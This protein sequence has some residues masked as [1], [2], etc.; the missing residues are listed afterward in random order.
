MERREPVAGGSP[1]MKIASA[2]R[3]DGSRV[4][5]LNADSLPRTREC[6][7]ASVGSHVR[8]RQAAVAGPY[9]TSL[10]GREAIL[11]LLCVGQSHRRERGT[12]QPVETGIGSH[13][14]ALAIDQ[15]LPHSVGAEPLLGREDF[16]RSRFQRHG[17]CPSLDMLEP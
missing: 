10:A 1:K 15:Q 3:P 5:A 11:M 17:R 9:G 13:P 2:G 6:H 14:N 12:T 4:I 7:Y 16:A 8:E